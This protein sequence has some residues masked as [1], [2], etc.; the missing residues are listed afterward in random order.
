MRV[1]S[2]SASKTHYRYA[3]LIINR[4]PF[5]EGRPS[6]SAC[7][8]AL[9]RHACRKLSQEGAK[10]P[11]TLRLSRQPEVTRQDS[12]L[13]QTF[14]RAQS[15]DVVA[16]IQRGLV[17]RLRGSAAHRLS[18]AVPPQMVHRVQFGGGLGK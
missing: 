3:H 5:I 6:V 11:L 15:D 14:A 17:D 13:P 10:S 16:H 9:P 8:S 7:F 12:R 2:V 18:L 1:F 4:H